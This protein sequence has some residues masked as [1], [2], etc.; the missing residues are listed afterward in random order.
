M[1]DTRKLLHM[2]LSSTHHGSLLPAR[3]SRG[4]TKET[5]PVVGA[6]VCIKLAPGEVAYG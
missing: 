3:P 2:F 6:V 5:A 1:S 4:N